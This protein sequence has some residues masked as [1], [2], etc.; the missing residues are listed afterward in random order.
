MICYAKIYQDDNLHNETGK[1]VLQHVVH[2]I[3]SSIL[4]V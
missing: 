3:L 1:G 2:K 4:W